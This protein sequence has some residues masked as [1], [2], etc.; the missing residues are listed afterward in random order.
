M[1]LSRKY[2]RLT[3]HDYSG[4]EY[5]ITVCTQNRK[6]YFGE[7][8]NSEMHLSE[9]GEILS[10]NIENISD[11][12]HDIQIPLYVVMPNHFHAIISV[13]GAQDLA[14]AFTGSPTM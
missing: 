3:N 13:V 7:I 5:F 14:T 4:A 11:H 8:D 2:T 6:K 12:F 1:T 9:L 10:S